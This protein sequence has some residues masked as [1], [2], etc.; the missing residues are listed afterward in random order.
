MA[1]ILQAMAI[2]EMRRIDPLDSL[3]EKSQGS[4]GRPLAGWR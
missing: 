2:T 1:S 4:G 3:A